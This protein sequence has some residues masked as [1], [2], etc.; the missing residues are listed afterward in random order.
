MK[1]V[2]LSDIEDAFLFV[3][4]AGYGENAACINTETGQYT[5]RVNR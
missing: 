4:S 1:G 5:E 3:S 2:R